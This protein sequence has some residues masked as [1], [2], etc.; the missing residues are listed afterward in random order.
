MNKKNNHRGHS[1]HRERIEL[2]YNIY[3][4]LSVLII[5]LFLL[6]DH[7]ISNTSE[8]TEGT[9]IVIDKVKN[10]VVIGFNVTLENTV[11]TFK[12]LKIFVKDKTAKSRNNLTSL[13]HTLTKLGATSE[14]IVNI[15]SILHKA[16]S[17]NGKLVIM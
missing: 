16:G 9:L 12:N 13:I 1:E 14:D 11:I 5:S 17:L 7:L 10:S 2:K 15:L 4:F 8:N 3:K 6:T